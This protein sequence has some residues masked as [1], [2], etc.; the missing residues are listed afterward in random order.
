MR[1]LIVDDSKTVRIQLR[2]ALQDAGYEVLE[3]GTADEAL[4]ILLKT[5]PINLVLTDQNMPEKT[6]IEMLQELRSAKGGPHCDVMVIFLSS[7]S[8]LEIRSAAKQL[9]AKGFISKPIK[10]S[11]VI[12]SIKKL[13]V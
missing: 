9:G 6:G 2:K 10:M 11:Q 5:E 1:I 7:D 13:G 4:Q 12:E 3:A 8:T